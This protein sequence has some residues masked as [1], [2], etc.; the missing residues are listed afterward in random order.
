MSTTLLAWHHALFDIP[1]TWE[2][3]RFLNRSDDGQLGL[4][5]RHG[6]TMLFFWRTFPEQ[7][8]V[9]HRLADLAQANGIDLSPGELR[10]RATRHGGWECL[11]GTDRSPCFAGRYLADRNVLL[12]AIF[13]PHRET[14][15]A[16]CRQVLASFRP[17][18]PKS[19]R[20]AAF[21]LDIEA[22]PGYRLAEIEPLPAMQRF[23]F[24]NDREEK[25]NLVRFGLA[26][27]LLAGDDLATFAARRKGR[28]TVLRRLDTFRRPAGHEGIL[29]GYTTRGSGN[30]LFG[31]ILARRW[32]G[33]LWVWH[34]PDLERIWCLE[35]HARPKHLI[36]DL[37]SRVHSP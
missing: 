26:S 10:K 19:P 29:L 5:D 2:V 16:R 21:G 12:A 13:P 27:R 15:A 24:L 37:P 1:R 4:S 6:E 11:P 17:N 22:P 30:T 20:W 9:R 35:H 32:E 8:D 14:T 23:T 36:D 7:P 33:R 3:I 31:A 25:I 18:D 34:R 28:H